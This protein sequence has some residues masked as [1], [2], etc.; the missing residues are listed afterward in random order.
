MPWPHAPFTAK[1]T[2]RITS[3]PS[4]YRTR[5]DPEGRAN[6]TRSTKEK[7]KSEAEKAAPVIV[8]A[9]EK[10]AGAGT[11]RG[12]AIYAFLQEAAQLAEAGK[13]NLATGTSPREPPLSG[14]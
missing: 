8:D 10:E 1:Q 7:T 13:L 2:L 4:A 6:C 5:T 12:R 14:R 3:F 9:A 11:D